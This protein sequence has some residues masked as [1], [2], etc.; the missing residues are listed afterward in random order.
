MHE[1][2]RLEDL[3]GLCGCGH[4]GVSTSSYE[5]T[6]LSKLVLY[7]GI[8]LSA[9]VAVLYGIRQNQPANRRAWFLIAGAMG[10]FLTADV[11]Y[12]VLEL[13]SPIARPRSRRSPTSSTSA[14]YPLMIV[15]LLMLLR[16][17]SPGRDVAGILDAG[18][19]AVATFAVL[20]ILVHGHLPAD[21]RT[22]RSG[23]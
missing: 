10:S 12:Y 8:G 15:G 7:N 4:C 23:A 22:P 14:M 5:T 9:V 18:L 20:G 11:V 21:R 6:S 17:V 3:S 16:S 2:E 19:V 1:D 13:T